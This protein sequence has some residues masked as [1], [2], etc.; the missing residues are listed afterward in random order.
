MCEIIAEHCK[1]VSDHQQSTKQLLSIDEGHSDGR[2][3]CSAPTDLTALTTGL[4]VV[5]LN[6]QILEA[7]LRIAA[8]HQR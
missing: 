8:T 4:E 3:R 1:T 6:Q 7:R 5:N 2:Y